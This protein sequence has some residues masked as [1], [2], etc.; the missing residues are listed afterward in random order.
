MLRSQSKTQHSPHKMWENKPLKTIVTWA[1]RIGWLWSWVRARAH[2][3]DKLKFSPRVSRWKKGRCWFLSVYI[4]TDF[5][6]FSEKMGVCQPSDSGSLP[7]LWFQVLS[8]QGI[9]QGSHL[10]WVP[11]PVDIVTQALS[12]RQESDL[13][14]TNPLGHGGWPV[15]EMPYVFKRLQPHLNKCTLTAS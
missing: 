8:C 6:K 14:S 10:T 1:Q 2:T 11:G 4:K 9:T 13:H 7:H 3:Q 5:K 12:W 15:L